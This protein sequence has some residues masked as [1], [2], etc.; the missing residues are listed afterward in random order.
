MPQHQ[1]STMV[2]RGINVG[3]H[4]IH[5]SV[6][7]IDIEL[8]RHQVLPLVVSLGSLRASNSQTV[9]V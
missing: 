3:K 5:R 1:H 9:H 8:R 7:D 6:W 4:S 2:E